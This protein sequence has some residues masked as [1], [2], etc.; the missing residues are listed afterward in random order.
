MITT[1][2]EGEGG[3][4][5]DKRGIRVQKASDQQVSTAGGDGEGWG[6]RGRGETSR[7]TE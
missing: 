3:G 1:R 5:G 2:R 6:D 4:R 7:D